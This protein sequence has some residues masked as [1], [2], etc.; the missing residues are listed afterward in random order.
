[1]ASKL[2]IVNLTAKGFVEKL[3]N[4]NLFAF[5]LYVFQQ[6]DC[7]PR[8]KLKKLEII[9]LWVNLFA[10]F[11]CV[12]F[13]HMDRVI[14]MSAFMSLKICMFISIK[15]RLVVVDTGLYPPLMNITPSYWNITCVESIKYKVTWKDSRISRPGW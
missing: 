13:C 6:R 2:T 14:C 11:V 4:L 15:A 9:L 7:W 3:R 8:K 12:H 10:N 1:M 5:Q